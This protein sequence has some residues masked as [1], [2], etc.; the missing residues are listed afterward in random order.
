[1]AAARDSAAKHGSVPENAPARTLAFET[2]VS[3]PRLDPIPPVVTR[4]RPSWRGFNALFINAARA[5]FWPEV[6]TS[7][8]TA[9]GEHAWVAL[10]NP[11]KELS[12]PQ[13][14][15]LSRFLARGGNLLVLDSV[16]NVR[17]TAAR[18][19]APYGVVPAMAVVAPAER[20]GARVPSL[21]GVAAGTSPAL[22][23]R[24]LSGGVELI[25]VPVGRG[26]VYLATD[27][28]LFSDAAV[29]G[30]YASPG[31]LELERLR[32]QAELFARLGAT[33]PPRGGGP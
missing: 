18:I 30:V 29:G 17:S 8:E 25:G 7:L 5:G 32:G 28:A 11:R 1:S 14:H 2:E 15:A 19:L 9:L 26:R 24:V 20:R 12:Q 33:E 31:E 10:V 13:A 3:S 16:L 23:R 27:G 22:Q 6:V 4:A 21:S